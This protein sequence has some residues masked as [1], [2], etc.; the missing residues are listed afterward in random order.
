M[1]V[2]TLDKYYE[3][4]EKKTE[5]LLLKQKKDYEDLTLL[6]L[7]RDNSTFITHKATQKCLDRFWYG[8][9]VINKNL[10]FPI[11]PFKKQ[12]WLKVTQISIISFKICSFF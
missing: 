8:H 5:T 10:E 11:L 1:I 7:F 4:G 2:E 6:Q 9:Q 12:N 3:K